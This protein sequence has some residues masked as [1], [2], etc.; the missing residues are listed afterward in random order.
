MPQQKTDVSAFSSEERCALL[1][2]EAAFDLDKAN[3]CPCDLWLGDPGRTAHVA[4][5]TP[6][7]LNFILPFT[8]PFN[9]TNGRFITMVL[10]FFLPQIAF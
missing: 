9:P 3:T 2:A 7:S 1:D 5:K 4:T 10:C 8:R 6:L